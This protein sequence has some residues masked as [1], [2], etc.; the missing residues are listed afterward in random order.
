MNDEAP[1]TFEV[2]GK[3]YELAQ[4]DDMTFREARLMK[5]YTPATGA[6]LVNALMAADPDAWF[7]V[8]LVSMQRARGAGTSP[9]LLEEELGETNFMATVS[10][11]FED[12]EEAD[13]PPP[14]SP[15]SDVDSSGP[16]PT[17]TPADVGPP[18]SET[19][20]A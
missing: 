7:A 3:S 9:D 2:D 15:A 19:V 5:S 17:P 4:V 14:E 18:P 8:M 1:T 12:E 13:V 11:F 10:G 6:E 20:S 16:E